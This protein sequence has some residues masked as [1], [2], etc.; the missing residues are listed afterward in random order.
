MYPYILNSFTKDKDWYDDSKCSSNIVISWI[1][2]DKISVQ[3]LRVTLRSFEIMTM[4][5]QPQKRH[6]L[7][8]N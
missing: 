1:S 8:Y 3:I 5:I 7:M 2:D 4:S 6:K